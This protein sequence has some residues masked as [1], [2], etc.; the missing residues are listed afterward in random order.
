MQFFIRREQILKSLQQIS[1]LFSRQSSN[2][3]ANLLIQVN[4]KDVIFTS[5]DLEIEVS[6]SISLSLENENKKGAIAVSARKFFDVLKNLPNGV[7]ILVILED[8]KLF[9]RYNNHNYFSLSTMA[10]SDF[11]IVNFHSNE[12]VEFS[13]EKDNL[14]RLINS[15][16]FSMAY[17]DVR[18]F[19]NG[20]VFEITEEGEFRTIATD[21]HRLAMCSISLHEDIPKRLIILPRKS[22][23]ELKR[24][25]NNINSQV[26]IQIGISNIRIQIDEYIFIS[27]LI[28]SQFP[29]YRRILSYNSSNV[30]QIH[31]LVLKQALIRTSILSNEKFR[32]ITMFFNTNQLKIQS[33]N[34]IKER[35]E[36][37]LDII[38]LGNPI[39]ISFNVDYI[40]DVLNVIQNEYVDLYFTNELSSMQIKEVNNL[41][42]SYFTIMPIRI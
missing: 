11:P 16:H 23:I 22:I 9:I 7:N 26:T 38:Y 39:V 20:M 24:L 30:I 6:F 35:A 32:S 1:G 3:S 18:Y 5:T 19:L 15:T 4:N 28:E 14:K 25:F 36:E 17:Q 33:E 42:K 10:A 37:I 40:I 12:I 13:I 27:R 41:H 2:L 34:S 31:K 21:G 29:D 8:L